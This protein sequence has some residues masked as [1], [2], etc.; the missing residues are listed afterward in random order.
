MLKWEEQMQ[1]INFWNKNNDLK[2]KLR[3]RHN[4]KRSKK[5]EDKKPQLLTIKPN[6]FEKFKNRSKKKKKDNDS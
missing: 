3:Q 1:S 4:S 5:Y 2:K 6:N